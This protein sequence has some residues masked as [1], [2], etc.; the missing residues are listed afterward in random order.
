[1]NKMSVIK[2]QNKYY[3]NEKNIW[4]KI[5]IL[6]LKKIV[7]QLNLFKIKRKLGSKQSHLMY[8]R[9]LPLLENELVNCT[10][11]GTYFLKLQGFAVSLPEDCP[12]VH[13]LSHNLF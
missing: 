6:I 1:M 3:C 13:F 5:G 10:C 11:T 12:T 7:I 8:K 2:L 4:N 9:T